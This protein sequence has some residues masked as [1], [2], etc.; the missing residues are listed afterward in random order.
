MFEGDN[1]I[2]SND[3]IVRLSKHRLTALRLKYIRIP[4]K[5]ICPTLY[6]VSYLENK[7]FSPPYEPLMEQ[8]TAVALKE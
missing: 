7:P 3:H 8:P 5:S 6:Y 1:L 4:S 2:L